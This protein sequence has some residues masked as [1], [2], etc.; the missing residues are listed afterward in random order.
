MTAGRC[1]AC[2]A[3]GPF[4]VTLDRVVHVSRGHLGKVAGPVDEQTA[5]TP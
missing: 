5:G 2:G 1:I 3:A 4:R